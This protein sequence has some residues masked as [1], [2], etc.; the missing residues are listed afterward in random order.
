MLQSV[1]NLNKKPKSFE[2][3]KTEQFIYKVKIT[4]ACSIFHLMI[5]T[6][7]PPLTIITDSVRFESLF[8]FCL[9]VTRRPLPGC[10]YLR[11]PY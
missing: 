1:N 2:K 6:G 3:F 11:D 4:L 5:K 7:L 10:N 9:T 8:P